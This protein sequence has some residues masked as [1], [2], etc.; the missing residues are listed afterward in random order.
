M[1]TVVSKLNNYGWEN[2]VPT[3][4][5]IHQTLLRHGTHCQQPTHSPVITTLPAGWTQW[6]NKAKVFHDCHGSGALAGSC[7]I[8]NSQL[9]PG[10]FLTVIGLAMHTV[11]KSHSTC[12]QGAY[13]WNVFS[14]RS[15]HNPPFGNNCLT[16]KFKQSV[17]T[18]IAKPGIA[19][20]V[21]L[22]IIL[23]HLCADF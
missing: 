22:L 16:H 20:E 13:D 8:F 5:S 6:L 4:W 3:I 19:P 7:I 10:S 17:N 14:Q 12:C 21:S 1:F 23:S 2:C 15:R 18:E 11:P 9:A